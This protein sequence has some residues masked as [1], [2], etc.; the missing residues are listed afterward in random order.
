MKAALSCVDETY[1]DI[2]YIT[3]H[4]RVTLKRDEIYFIGSMIG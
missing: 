1:V 4:T 2:I 3:K